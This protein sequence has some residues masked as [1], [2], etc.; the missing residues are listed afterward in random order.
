MI[1]QKFGG[2]AMQNQQQRAKCIQHIKKALLKYRSVVVVVSAMGRGDDAYSTDRLLNVTDAFEK[3]SEAKDLAAACGELIASAV[4]SAELVSE[5]IDNTIIY[6]QNTGIRTNGDFSNA[7]IEK[8]NTSH[9]LK[10]LETHSCLI[11]PGFQGMNKQGQFMTLGRGG[12]DLTAIAL[13]AAL[14]ASHVEFYKDV[15]A[16]M[17]ADPRTVTHYE[18]FD[19][20][21]FDEFLPL[22]DC[23]RPIIQKKAAIHAKKTA[24]PLHIRGIA[25][26]EEGTWILP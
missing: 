8:I 18:R 4:M 21:T 14:Q 26:N 7:A 22:L 17:S 20:L 13:A 23:S 25:S 11:V 5:G 19:K 16:V 10:T 9:L 24:T 12:S 1:I 2:V 15:P 3:S 6:G